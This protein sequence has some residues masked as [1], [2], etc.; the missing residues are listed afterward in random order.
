MFFWRK[1]EEV[2]EGGVGAFS[3]LYLSGGGGG[4]TIADCLVNKRM[5]IA[6]VV[7]N[8]LCH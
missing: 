1:K 3:E 7:L 2:R 4:G 8:I 5:V 6:P